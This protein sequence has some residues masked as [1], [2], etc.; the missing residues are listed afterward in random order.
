MAA[1]DWISGPARDV[2]AA[3]RVI[4][5]VQAELRA[6]GV[7]TRLKTGIV[8]ELFGAERLAICL[9]LDFYRNPG[10]VKTHQIEL[11]GGTPLA[12]CVGSGFARSFPNDDLR[13]FPN[14]PLP[15]PDGAPGWPASVHSQHGE[16]VMIRGVTVQHIAPT[17]DRVHEFRE[18]GCNTVFALGIQIEPR[19]WTWWCKH[20]QS[21]T[22]Q[23]PRKRG[24]ELK[25]MPAE[26]DPR[27]VELDTRRRVQS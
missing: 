22:G 16:R 11:S 9:L 24:N 8:R 2:P 23:A 15:F 21:G 20:C 7:G 6:S 1:T 13:A 18:V 14:D 5:E 27:V 10:L 4:A 26:P 17:H 19:P 25:L 12:V 3:E